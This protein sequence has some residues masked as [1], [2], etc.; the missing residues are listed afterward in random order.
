MFYY[1]VFSP[2]YQVKWGIVIPMLMLLGYLHQSLIIRYYLLDYIISWVFALYSTVVL[3][4]YGYYKK[5]KP[6][7][8]FRNFNIF[9]FF[10]RL[11]VSWVALYCLA[12]ILFE[13]LYY[14]VVRKEHPKWTGYT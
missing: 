4:R 11:L 1:A 14:R 2:I 12:K 6:W 3:R 13:V 7:I 10:F 5:E 9:Y 8:L